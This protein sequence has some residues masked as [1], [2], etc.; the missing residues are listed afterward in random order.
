VQKE[1]G[2]KKTR[3]SKLAFNY[4]S[5]TKNTFQ[6]KALYS[7]KQA[8]ITAVFSMSQAVFSVQIP[9]DK[10]TSSHCRRSL[11]GRMLQ[12]LA[13]QHTQTDWQIK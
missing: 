5:K 9:A 7:A 2:K 1:S 11:C 13:T 3:C 8:Q 4:F 6:L 10:Y 12:L